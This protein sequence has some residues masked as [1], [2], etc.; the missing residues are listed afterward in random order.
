MKSAPEPCTRKTIMASR[1]ASCDDHC[2]RQSRTQTHAVPAEM[3]APHR[4]EL[5][6]EEDEAVARAAIE[7][8]DP[9]ELARVANR[10]QS[11][12]EAPLLA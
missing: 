11:I 12:N 1:A 6:R 3:A 2:T 10:V 7:S 9:E 4:E 5:L 8:D